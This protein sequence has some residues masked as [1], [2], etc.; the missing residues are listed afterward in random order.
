MTLR[1]PPERHALLLSARARQQTLAFHEVYQARCG[2]EGTF[3]QT[4]RTTGMR[5]ARYIGQSKT[6]L[7]HVFTA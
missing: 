6:H 4:T 5:R 1:F 3:S 7:Q 2:V